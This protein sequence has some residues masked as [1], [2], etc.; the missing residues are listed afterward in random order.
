MNIVDTLIARVEDY[1][2]DTKTPCKNYATYKAAE[3]ATAAMAQKAATYFDVNNRADAPSANY[4]VFFVEPWGRWVG[5]I[6]LSELLSRKNSTG[7]YMGV[8]TGFFTF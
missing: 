3:K 7:G 8:C 2:K 1:R 4:V 5:A 6:N